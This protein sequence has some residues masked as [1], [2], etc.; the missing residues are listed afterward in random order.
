M[1]LIITR[2]LSIH[3]ESRPF[4]HP[5]AN[6]QVFHCFNALNDLS[7][8]ESDECEIR[9]LKMP[10]SVMTREVFLLRAFEAG[11]DAVVVLV[12]PESQCDYLEGSL[13]ARKRVERIKIILDEVGIGSQRLNIYNISRL[14]LSEAQKIVQGTIRDIEALGRNPAAE[15]KTELN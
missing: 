2:P 7:E 1:A 13:R 14:D 8:L 4:R 12:C 11:A 3:T 10:C 5:K 6:I 9:S 15:S